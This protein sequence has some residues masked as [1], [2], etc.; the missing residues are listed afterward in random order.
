[1]TTTYLIIL[2]IAVIFLLF[3]SYTIDGPKLKMVK[4]KNILLPKLKNGY[5]K[6]SDI[7][8]NYKTLSDTLESIKLEN[9]NLSISRESVHSIHDDTMAYN[10][11]FTNP[12]KTLRLGAKLTPNFLSE[13]CYVRGLF[14]S[15]YNGEYNNRISYDNKDSKSKILIINFMWEYITKYDNLLYSE[16]LDRLNNLK[17]H[18]ESQL[19]ALKRDRQLS[20]LIEKV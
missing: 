15:D 7:D 16:E 11:S 3:R 13:P 9:W 1:M 14:I 6:F 19:I 20:K 10:I 8:P 12:S 5:P 18:V 2:T 17:S 4:E